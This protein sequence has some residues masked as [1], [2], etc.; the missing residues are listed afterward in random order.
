MKMNKQTDIV[1]DSTGSMGEEL[2]AMKKS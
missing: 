1:F 2:S